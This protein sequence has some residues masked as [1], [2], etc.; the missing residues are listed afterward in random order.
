MDRQRYRHRFRGPLTH[1][2]QPRTDVGQPELVEH[3]RRVCSQHQHLVE[4]LDFV[5]RERHKRFA[6]R[7]AELQPRSAAG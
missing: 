1:L 2:R 4:F 6:N 7:G 3:A 5:D